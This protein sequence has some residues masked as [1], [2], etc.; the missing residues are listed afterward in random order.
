MIETNENGNLI[1]TV[2][3]PT[4]T[5]KEFKLTVNG[6]YRSTQS[7]YNEEMNQTRLRIALPQNEYAGSPVTV[8]LKKR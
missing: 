5:L 1:V 2:A 3:D 7:G 6:K 4:Q 8:E